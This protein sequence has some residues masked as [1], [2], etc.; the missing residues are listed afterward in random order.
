MVKFSG[1]DMLL[2]LQKNLYHTELQE[3]EALLNSVIENIPY[4]FWALDENN[5]YFIQSKAS[6]VYWGTLLGKNFNDI[7]I[8]ES[9]KIVFGKTLERVK[10]G[11]VVNEV[12]RILDVNGDLYYFQNISGPLVIKNKIKGAL[13][14]NIDITERKIVEE[15]LVQN[16]EK[17]RNIFNNST[18]SIIIH[19]VMGQIYESNSIFR[20]L[21]DYTE[22]ECI[23]KQIF[24]FVD[25][26]STLKFKNEIASLSLNN[27]DFTT[28]A[29]LITRSN[30]FIP[31][32]IKSKVITYL[33][34]NA[35]LTIIRN[36]SYRKRF[37]RK[38]LDAIIE[39]EEKERAQLA[40]DLHDEIGPLLSS[41]KMYI[42]L[43]K[44]TKDIEKS[45]FVGEQVFTL[46]TEA[47]T[48]IR[49]ISNSLSPHVLTNYGLIEAVKNVIQSVS[50]FIEIDFSSNCE[51]MR[52]ASN[53]ETV[54]YRVFK[55][56]LNNTVKHAQATNIII[57]FIFENDR[58]TFTYKD[59]G[60]GFDYE[61][62]F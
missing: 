36:V 25:H 30:S 56:L 19:S 54:Y 11:E 48:S 24:D 46:V 8:P 27:L 6:K 61:K 55:E 2:I 9:S 21:I 39:T 10:K 3:R 37:E 45:K 47:I 5:N 49:E 23:D 31:I 22:D 35:L 41:M 26:E 59:D 13:G 7:K 38:L 58:L 16:E 44:D 14:F 50:K 60:K 57:S 17:F 1:M 12:N 53:T 20:N 40:A 51:K 43:L 42:S 33:G 18:D 15:K 62:S 4:D 28:E 29:I 52:F 34:R 32:E